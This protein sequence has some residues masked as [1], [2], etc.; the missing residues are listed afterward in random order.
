MDMVCN[1]EQVSFNSVFRL[2]FFAVIIY[3]KV[4]KYAKTEYAIP[5]MRDQLVRFMMAVGNV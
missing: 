1:E 2:T 3:S 4:T 5:L